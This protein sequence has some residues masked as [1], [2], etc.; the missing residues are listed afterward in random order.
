MFRAFSSCVRGAYLVSLD[1]RTGA[2]RFGAG[3]TSRRKDNKRE[4]EIGDERQVS[5]G[6]RLCSASIGALGV[7]TYDF[8]SPL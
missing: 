1:S 7:F 8:L 5:V 2:K 4:R 6:G 3:G